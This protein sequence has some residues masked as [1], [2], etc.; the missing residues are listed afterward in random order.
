M[1]RILVTGAAG[2]IGSELVPALRERYGADR[3]VASDLRMLPAGSPAAEG[4]F[5]VVDC[6]HVSEIE[7]AVQRHEIDAIYHLAALLSAVAE[8]QPRV[9]W[10][11]NMGGLYR[12]LEV[13]RQHGCAVFLP[14]SIGAFGP[15]T[16]REATPQD[17]LQRPTTIYGITK[18]SAELLC[19]YY[20]QRFGLDTRGIRLP[21]L[22]SHV[23]KPGGGTT[24]W[25][26]EIF[27]QAIRYA[28]YTCF[29]RADCCLDMMYMP[30]AI[31]AMIELMEA[32]PD[33]LIH[34]NAFNLSAMH[35]T[36]ERLAQEIRRHVPDFAIDYDVDPVRQAIADS[37]PASVDDSAAREEWG[38]QPRYDIASTTRDMLERLREKLRPAR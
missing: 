10:N 5:E 21:G 36:P 14:S 28:H 30:D 9:A 26:V 13:A 24:D 17:T 3:V 12:V 1:G 33:R 7:A 2:Q 23:A 25:A 8:E 37:W 38:W 4:P 18:V 16:P 32:D 19:D 22:I 6:V 35:F 20:H 31:R 27:Y 15:T 29:L 34:R 11:V